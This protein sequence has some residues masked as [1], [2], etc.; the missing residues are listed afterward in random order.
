MGCEANNPST[1][2]NSTLRRFSAIEK[3]RGWSLPNPLDGVRVF[4]EAEKEMSWLTLE[5]IPQLL[6][7]CHKYGHEDLT[8]IAKVCLATGAR[9]GEAQRLTRPQLSP[10][11]LTFT[12]TKG[13]KIPLP[14]RYRSGY[15]RNFLRGR[16]EYLS[17]AIRSSRKCW[18]LRI[19]S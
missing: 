13:K 8:T 12:K 17:P 2:S 7:A 9:W 14:C 16:G 3:V 11:K 6:S 19:S 4:K 18:R 5:Q 10:Y 15:M 1:E